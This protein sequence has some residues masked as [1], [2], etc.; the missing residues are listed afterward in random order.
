MFD[1]ISTHEGALWFFA[2]AAVFGHRQRTDAHISQQLP[3]TVVYHTII[4]GFIL[5]KSGIELIGIIKIHNIACH[6]KG[7]SARTFGVKS[8]RTFVCSDGGG[9]VAV[10]PCATAPAI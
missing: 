2:R 4:N 10:L 6:F 3:Y 1:T 7:C 9:S 8:R 5:Q